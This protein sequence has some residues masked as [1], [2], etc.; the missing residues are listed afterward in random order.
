MRSSRL[1]IYPEMW[2]VCFNQAKKSVSNVLMY[3]KTTQKFSFVL[4]Q[5]HSTTRR[6]AQGT[7]ES[8]AVWFPARYLKI[9]IPERPK[10]LPCK[11]PNIAKMPANVLTSN[12]LSILTANYSL[13]SQLNKLKIASALKTAGPLNDH[14][15][16]CNKGFAQ[17]YFCLLIIHTL[18]RA[19]R[20]LFCTSSQRIPLSTVL[21]PQLES[22]R[23][24]VRKTW[25]STK[26]TRR[27][28]RILSVLGGDYFQTSNAAGGRKG[29][30]GSQP[31]AGTPCNPGLFPGG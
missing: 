7:G 4:L 26:P 14:D 24:S 5:I 22:L 15:G 23:N 29:Q 9:I 1:L 13:N 28:K 2:N 25:L 6:R 17:Q 12:F 18:S 16:W 10:P 30:G 21:C 27:A 20:C 11:K 8:I 3:R 31:R 19:P